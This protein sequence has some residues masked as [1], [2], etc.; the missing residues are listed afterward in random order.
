MGSL[1]IPVAR[2]MGSLKRVPSIKVLHHAPDF[3][4]AVGYPL[5]AKVTH[6][7]SYILLVV[8][9]GI[10]LLISFNIPG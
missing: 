9:A 2:S 4:Q 3:H 6:L 5:M 1:S 7:I 8:F 10:S